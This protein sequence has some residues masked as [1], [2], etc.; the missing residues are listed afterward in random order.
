MSFLNLSLCFNTHFLSNLFL[1]HSPYFPASLHISISHFH[2]SVSCH[3]SFTCVNYSSAV[4][5][6]WILQSS[7]RHTKKNKSL[8]H[9]HY[10]TFSVYHLSF[11]SI[12]WH[13]LHIKCMHIYIP[14]QSYCNIT[15]SI[16]FNFNN[17]CTQQ[18]ET[19]QVLLFHSLL[20]V[21]SLPNNSVCSQTSCIWHSPTDSHILLFI[22]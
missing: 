21:A 1:K 14:N 16:P 8:H 9:M 6:K 7:R 18:L 15:T 4:E 19:S 5:N 20:R 13:L 22:Y 2:I 17:K 11:R 10:W 3:G 12:T